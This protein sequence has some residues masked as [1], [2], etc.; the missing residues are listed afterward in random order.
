M[1]AKQRV[2]FLVGCSF[3]IGL[4]LKTAGHMLI[5]GWRGPYADTPAVELRAAAGVQ[6][7]TEPEAQPGETVAR[8]VPARTRATAEPNR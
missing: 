3:V 1:N 2:V 7:A 4:H 5:D 8:N 6:V